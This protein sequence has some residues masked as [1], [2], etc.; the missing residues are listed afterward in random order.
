MKIIIILR[1]E[2]CGTSFGK[3][4]IPLFIY[5]E[6]IF[7][8]WPYQNI[9]LVR[10]PAFRV[11]RIRIVKSKTVIHLGTVLLYLCK[12]PFIA[13]WSW[14]L[15]F[16]INLFCWNLRAVRLIFYLH[17][18]LFL[19]CEYCFLYTAKIILFSDICKWITFF[20]TDLIFVGFRVLH[21]WNFHYENNH[22]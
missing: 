18:F 10:L 9:I 7:H 16:S 5:P 1:N 3:F 11:P 21:D 6:E 22:I 8:S 4:R 14:I 2:K 17:N 19:N 13:A 12:H 15:H 20:N